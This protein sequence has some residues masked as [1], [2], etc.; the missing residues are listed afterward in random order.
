MEDNDILNISLDKDGV[1]MMKNTNRFLDGDIS[2]GSELL[3][4]SAQFI[5]DNKKLS[6]QILGTA[7]LLYGG[8]KAYKNI[9]PAGPGRML[10]DFASN[11]LDGFYAKGNTSFDKMKLYG[12]ELAKTT[13]RL[14]KHAVNPREMFTYKQTGVSPLVVD[15]ID[16]L[17]QRLAEVDQMYIDGHFGESGQTAIDNAKK[18]KNRYV[19]ERHYKV[20]NDAAN[21][22]IFT[23]KKSKIL[24]D[25]VNQEGSGRKPWWTKSTSKEFLDNAGSRKVANYMLQPWKTG[26][27]GFD[28][29]LEFGQ[30]GLRFIKW[31]DNSISGV[32]R[33][34]QF[35]A[36]TYHVLEQL[37]N[38][39]DIKNVKDALAY[40]QRKGYKG[41]S[42]IDG[43][44]FFNFSPQWKSNFDWGGYNAVAEWDINNRTRVKFR[45]TDLRDTPMSPVFKDAKN[46][47]NYVESK[48]VEIADLKKK[49][50]VASA[51]SG[52]T[53]IRDYEPR[54]KSQSKLNQRIENVTKGELESSG[55]IKNIRTDLDT[56]S[57]R[58]KN[59]S[60]NITTNKTKK[61]LY[62]KMLKQFGKSRGAMGAGAIL[63]LASGLFGDD[64]EEDE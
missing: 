16:R 34:A 53:E 57:S 24:M 11:Y 42:I 62:N 1:D 2:G 13:G 35:N 44:L 40:V 54:Q 17:P 15:R 46:V 22:E 28:K 26:L 37:K 19:K 9:G 43:K 48:D 27:P 51:K 41:A 8:Q 32:L 39:R 7:S 64:K 30:K 63:L 52:K 31:N 14:I 23:G 29:S 12:K 59:Y 50:H 33:G 6:T 36:D 61:Q 25:Y 18:L 10:A 60:K 45:A 21:R 4:K 56:V 20:L 55:Q 49:G 47:L 5:A 38:K 3:D 58:T